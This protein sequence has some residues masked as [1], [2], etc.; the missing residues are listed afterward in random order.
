VPAKVKLTVYTGDAAFDIGFGARTACSAVQ[1]F[2][3]VAWKI[4]LDGAASRKLED[5]WQDLLLLIIDEIS[6]IGTAL[7]TRMHICTQQSKRAHFSERGRDP[8]DSTFGDISMILVGDFGQLEPIDDW[9][10]CDTEA[11]FATCPKKL[12]HLWEHHRKGRLLVTFFK[13]AIML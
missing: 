1:V 10:M 7:F 12:R 11:T 8:T 3:N 9:S 2:P 5:T 6:F 4:E 13:E